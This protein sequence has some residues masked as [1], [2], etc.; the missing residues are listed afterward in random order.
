MAIAGFTSSSPGYLGLLTTWLNRK[1]VSDLEWEL[2]YQ[3]F[4]TKA[5]IPPGSGR[6][7]RFNVFAPPPGGTSY[8]ASSTTALTEI[9]T[10]E[11]HIA[12]I[13]S[14]STNVTIY[15]YG[16]FHKTNAL[17][18]YA[19]V[20]GAREKLRKRLKDGARVTLDQLVLTTTNTGTNYLYANTD[21]DGGATAWNTGNVGVLGAAA[22][23]QA[24]KILYAAKVPAFTGIPGHP[25]NHFAA[26][27]GPKQEL[28]I[29]TEVTTS[30]I[31][32][33]DIVKHVPG[34]KA[35]EKMVNGYIGSIYGVACYTTQLFGTGSY[36]STSSG[37]ISFVLG[38]GGVGAMAFKDMEPRI[39]VNDVNSPYKN[40]DSIAWHAFFGTALIDS[41]R[42]VKMYS[43]S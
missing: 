34:V 26:I 31:T 24:R 35:Q 7:G 5:I 30:R 39:I 17:M 20:P 6:T 10:T 37:D 4:T 42:I 36:T 15:E 16:E 40:T 12:T 32:W 22:I 14:A 8:S 43:A 28:D 25:D 11:H 1:F 38:D 2:Q 33:S 21:A 29:V 3:K 19:A 27:L 23:I 13:T 41:D 18:M 9:N